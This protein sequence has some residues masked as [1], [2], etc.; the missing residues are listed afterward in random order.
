MEEVNELKT[1]L[2]DLARFRF[3]L[4]EGFREC[5]KRQKIKLAREILERIRQNRVKMRETRA[6]IRRF[7]PGYQRG[8]V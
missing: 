2:L 8:L 1:Y 4:I 6:E 3:K 7:E 5:K